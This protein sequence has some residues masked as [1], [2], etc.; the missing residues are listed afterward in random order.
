[1]KLRRIFE[2]EL[3]FIFAAPAFVWQVFFL[4]LPLVG[5]LFVSFTEYSIKGRF[6]YYVFTLE[7]Y[8]KLF[9][10][11]YISIILN[12]FILA[13]ITMLTCLIIAFPVSYFIAIKIQRHRTFFLF[14]LILPS[15]TN[16]IVQIYAWFFLLEKSGLFSQI[17]YNLGI[18]NFFPNF[19]NTYFA[20]WIGMVYCFLPFMIFPLYTVL[21]KMDKRLLEA[22][23][24]LG[25]SRFN[26]FRRIIFPL[27]L[28]GIYVGCV[29]VF[30][31]AFAEFVIPVLLGGSRHVYWGSVIVQKI[32]I[33]RDWATGFALAGVGVFLL[34]SFF[35]GAFFISWVYKSLKRKAV[36][37][38]EEE[39]TNFIDYWNENG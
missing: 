12:S 5:I 23:A 30:V 13:F 32:L 37:K 34:I 1:M 10:V 11:T 31:P 35:G 27:S 8:R 22:S 21:E 4:Y 26:T 33:A 38:L 6:F 29:L 25:A 15:W 16:F 3:P 39:P 9:D 17:I 2:E 20:T 18:V 36:Q 24:D 19:L 14:A 28:N 7:H